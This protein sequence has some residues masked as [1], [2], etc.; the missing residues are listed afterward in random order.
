MFDLLYNPTRVFDEPRLD[1]VLVAAVGLRNLADHVLASA[2]AA[3][4]RAGV[5]TRRH[6]RSG[7][8]LLTGLGV[9]PGTAYRLARVGRAAHELPAVT[10]AQRLAAMGA[11]LADAIGVGVAHIGARV[12]LDEQ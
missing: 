2:T 10:Q 4:E 7:A 8:Q 12:D 6:L 9:V 1:A 11:E 5:P 3:A